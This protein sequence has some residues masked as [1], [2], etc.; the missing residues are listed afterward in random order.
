MMKP[1]WHR[2]VVEGLREKGKTGVLHVYE[3]LFQDLPYPSDKINRRLE[4]IGAELK[5]R[6]QVRELKPIQVERVHKMKYEAHI[7]DPGNR[8]TF[9]AN[10]SKELQGQSASLQETLD[11]KYEES[12]QAQLTLN[13][14]T[15]D[16]ASSLNRL[17]NFTGSGNTKQLKTIEFFESEL[18]RKN[19]EKELIVGSA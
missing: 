2:R 19:H 9:F 5:N 7:R 6:I 1:N 3:E 18:S 14:K 11:R 4:A 8:T 17:N 10:P 12:D 16:L 15:I 13:S